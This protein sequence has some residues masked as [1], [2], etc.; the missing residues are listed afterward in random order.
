[1]NMSKAEFKRACSDILD[2]VDRTIANE[3]PAVKEAMVASILKKSRLESLL[4][5]IR[6]LRKKLK[7]IEKRV[8]AKGLYIDE[9]DGF[10]LDYHTSRE[11]DSRF[12]GKRASVQA[13]Q[14]ALRLKL[15]ETKPE[16]RVMLLRNHV[17]FVISTF[18]GIKDNLITLA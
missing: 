9:E 8:K 5:E 3:A 18:P 10:S 12:R 1:M 2:A 17:E 14:A 13:H 4:P 11:V 15:L 16:E 6:A 7:A